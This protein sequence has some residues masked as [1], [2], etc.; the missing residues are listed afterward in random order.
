MYGLN[1]R[2][3]LLLLK[4]II[5]HLPSLLPKYKRVLFFMLKLDILNA[6]RKLNLL[7][8]ATGAWTNPAEASPNDKQTMPN[9]GKWPRFLFQF[10]IFLTYIQ[11]FSTYYQCTWFY[12]RLHTFSGLLP[13]EHILLLFFK[14]ISKSRKKSSVS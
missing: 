6:I 8:V 10:H 2:L 3:M 13:N 14:W 7:L 9:R 4:R 1:T 5:E 12:W 11:V